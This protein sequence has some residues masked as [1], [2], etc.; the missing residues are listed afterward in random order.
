MHNVASWCGK[1]GREEPVTAE[2]AEGQDSSV[3]ASWLQCC[4]NFPI[5]VR[6]TGLASLCVFWRPLMHRRGRGNINT[7]GQWRD[8]LKSRSVNSER[9]RGRGVIRTTGHSPDSERAPPRVAD[10]E[11]LLQLATMSCRTKPRRACLRRPP[12]Q[13]SACHARAG[14]S[15]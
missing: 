4:C 2:S 3:R 15:K 8:A 10:R 1:T 7:T 14:S 9:G 5:R 11:D 12:T 6:A 13:A